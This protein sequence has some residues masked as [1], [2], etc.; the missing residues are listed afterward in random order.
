MAQV[1]NKPASCC[2]KSSGHGLRGQVSPGKGG[3]VE[4]ALLQRPPVIN[5]L[6]TKKQADL[7][8]PLHRKP[9]VHHVGSR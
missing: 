8:P 2:A 9:T 5:L 7:Q 1:G 6:R 4:Q 3:T